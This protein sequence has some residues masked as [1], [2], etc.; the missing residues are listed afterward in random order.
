MHGAEM[1]RDNSVASVDCLME[2]DV[3]IL[4]GEVASK[5]PL[6]HS[7]GCNKNVVDLVT[8]GKVT[9]SESKTLT[10]KFSSVDDGE[11]RYRS[12]KR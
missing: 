9:E 7:S 4:N 2:T 3:G 10:G 8:S 6:R 5:L 11:K 12:H 1:V